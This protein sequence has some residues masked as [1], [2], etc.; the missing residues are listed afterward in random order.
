MKSL[1]SMKFSLLAVSSIILG[2]FGSSA[3][4][5]QRL[6]KDAELLPYLHSIAEVHIAP[7]L[8]R[9]LEKDVKITM[10]R[11]ETQMAKLDLDIPNAV[12]EDYILV[13]GLL[14]KALGIEFLVDILEKDKNLTMEKLEEPMSVLKLFQAAQMAIIAGISPKIMACNHNSVVDPK[15]SRPIKIQKHLMEN[16]TPRFEKLNKEGRF[17]KKVSE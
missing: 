8:S 3:N 17:N 12:C 14:D 13:W 11:Y 16:V 1:N 9:D 2:V 15:D 7:Y 4:A 6:S 5:Y 10:D